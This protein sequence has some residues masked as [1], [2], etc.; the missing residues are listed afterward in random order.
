[1]DVQLGEYLG[2]QTATTDCTITIADRKMALELKSSRSVE[3][4]NVSKVQFEGVRTSNL[5]RKEFL[6]AAAHSDA[7]VFGRELEANYRIFVLPLR[8]TGSLAEEVLTVLRQKQVR[9]ISQLTQF[10]VFSASEFLEKL[11]KIRDTLPDTEP[12]QEDVDKLVEIPPE[13]KEYDLRK[14]PRSEEVKEKAVK[15]VI[16]EKGATTVPKPA[17]KR[18]QKLPKW[19]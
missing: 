14:R 19:R 4:N 17:P 3:G 18:R 12:C 1:M 10:E 16:K 7:I 11:Q 8:T 13:A 2:V 5:V 9:N 15:K 6:Y